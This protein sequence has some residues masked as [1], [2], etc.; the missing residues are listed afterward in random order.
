MDYDEILNLARTQGYAI[1]P[2]LTD[3]R[4]AGLTTVAVPEDTLQRLAADGRLGYWS[5]A[6]LTAMARAGGP[7]DPELARLAAGGRLRGDYTYVLAADRATEETVATEFRRRVGPNVIDA[8]PLAGNRSLLE[9]KRLVDAAETIPLGPRPEE[10]RYLASLGFRVAPR[11]AN[12]PGATAGDIR[13]ELTALAVEGHASTVIFA[14]KEVLGYPN[15][16]EATARGLVDNGLTLGLIETP[17]QLSLVPQAGLGDLAR[18]VGYRAARV[19]AI[20]RKELDKITPAEMRDRWVRSAKERNIRVMYLRPFL[21]APGQDLRRVNLDHVRATRE[22]LLLNGY[23]VGP[24]TGFQEIHVP[25]WASVL[26]VTG[27]AAG[28]WFLL[29][30]LVALRFRTGLI[31][32]VASVAGALFAAFVFPG[33]RGGLGFQAMALASA[34]VFPTLGTAHPLKRWLRMKKGGPLSTVLG[35]ATVSIVT[36]TAISLVGAFFIGSLLADIRYLLEFDYFRGVKLVHVVPMAFL[37]LIYLAHHGAGETGEGRP[38]G[39]AGGERPRGGAVV[40]RSADVHGPPHDVVR[41]LAQFLRSRVRAEHL[42]LLAGAAVAGYIYIGRTGNTSGLPVT[43]LELN[44]RSG[45]ERLLVARPRTKE[46][47]I[48]H[49]ALIAAAW[50]AL[51]GFEG[52]LLP[53]ILAGSIAQVSLVNSFEHLRTPFALSLLRGFNGLILGYVIGVVVLPAIDWTARFLRGRLGGAGR[54]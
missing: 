24:A 52:L 2:L 26:I 23:R 18:L 11:L 9:V 37:S 28:A 34:L 27:I 36:A 25:R 29:L 35:A 43:P 7:I 33:S 21:V 44:L 15:N 32:L 19:Y 47:L 51:R 22:E 16:L 30:E 5:G 41:E 38:R 45:L 31:L 48:G 17:V 42:V 14:G 4:A 46:F 6:A 8:L 1:E 40:R 13:R 50:A 53:L 20:S 3:L 49:P 10:Y 54:A 12:Y 39:E